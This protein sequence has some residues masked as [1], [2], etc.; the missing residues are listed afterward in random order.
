MGS[1][2]SSTKG[3]VSI[4]IGSSIT[5]QGEDQPIQWI[6]PNKT[7]SLLSSGF[8]AVK[9]HLIKT[10]FRE[11]SILSAYVVDIGNEGMLLQRLQERTFSTNGLYADVDSAG[12]SLECRG[13]ATLRQS[14]TQSRLAQATVRAYA[15][16]IIDTIDSRI[17]NSLLTNSS[18]NAGNKLS[19]F[20]YKTLASLL[21]CRN[22]ACKLEALGFDI[23]LEVYL[24]FRSGEW[25]YFGYDEVYRE[26]LV[27]CEK[28]VGFNPLASQLLDSFMA[29]PLDGE[30]G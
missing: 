18:A 11:H 26:G 12:R 19:G 3:L 20:D 1:R 30:S 5:L 17:L 13:E 25:L 6:D 10:Y 29:T 8:A 21:D 4:L 24:V 2:I 14:N 9:N 16:A 23:G 27:I 28:E 22:L 15:L 7:G